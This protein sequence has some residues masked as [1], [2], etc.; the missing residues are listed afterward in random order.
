MKRIWLLTQANLRKSKGNA[1]SLLVM[2]MLAAAFMNIGFLTWRNYDNAFDMRAKE[3]NTSDITAVLQN[4]Y[5][6]Y[7]KTYE[8][9]FR[10][11]TR[12]KE[13]EV[14]DI[15]LLH[16]SCA[17]G[18][19]ITNRMVAVL[20]TKDP[21]TMNQYVFV[22]KAEVEPGHAVYLPYLFQ[23]AGGYD[24]GDS[25]SIEISSAS[26]NNKSF[27]Y[28][29]AG[30]FDEIILGTINASTT[31]IILNDSSYQE[32]SKAYD[33]LLDAK[34]FLMQIVDPSFNEVYAT[35]H[36][37]DLSDNHILFDIN[38]YDTLKMSRTITSS[39]GSLL[40][41]AFSVILALISM[42]V[43]R[44]RIANTIEEDMQNIGALKA[45]GYKGKEIVGAILLQFLCI[46][47]CG[48]VLGI[49]ISYG[50]LPSVI[51]LFA[52]QTGLLWSQGF[53]VISTVL[54]F[55]ILLLSVVFVVILSTRRASKVP[56]IHA[57]RNGIH[58]HNFKKNYFPFETSRGS[59]IAM[60]AKK[61]CVQELKQ[62]TL[63]GFIILGISFAAV[64]ATILFYNI[65]M[66][67]DNFLET[68]VGEI[69]N[70]QVDAFNE[71][72]ASIMKEEIEDMDGVNKTLYFY[73]SNMKSKDGAAVYMYTTDDFNE[74]SCQDMVY[75]GR[76]P[77][78]ENEVAIGGILSDIV[79][80]DVGDTIELVKDDQSYTYVIT[81]LIQGSNFMGHDAAITTDGYLQLD[82]DYKKTSIS[83]YLDDNDSGDVVIQ[84]INQKYGDKI[85][86]SRDVRKSVEASMMTYR[87]IVSLLAC[88]I[89]V[90]TAI[91]ISLTLY[92]VIKTSLLRKKRELGIQKAIGFTSKQL[93]LQNSLSFLP[94]ILG[95]SILGGTITYFT[96]NPIL[97]MLFSG[98]G[99]MKVNFEIQ[100]WMIVL[101]SGS[102]TLFGFIISILVSLRI[103]KISPYALINE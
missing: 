20:N 5:P 69:V 70:L 55:I 11:D 50:A 76:F 73:T 91:V 61:T 72:D 101:I 97:S 32:L 12:T 19:S 85:A 89:L 7:T 102:I 14:R 6:D 23:I 54:T 68:T 87:G 63:I 83:V 66:N 8:Q 46:T 51:L 60:N 56:P 57:L 67:F 86:M 81:G 25:F 2:I 1:I 80:K 24:I 38:I 53:D 84:D 94:I 99:M 22:E 58:S 77:K 26:G 49:V 3:L 15:L 42:V 96:A 13:I 35:D 103:H 29:I 4:Q 41:V 17:Y 59:I 52:K 10:D 27:T 82:P 88:I 90:I 31:G 48:S 62:N 95:S 34:M 100:L 16:G 36:M 9:Q 47:I 98:I 18:D 75:E 43:I 40:V 65:S 33:G 71:E 92:L 28:E 37:A 64:F 44:F 30:F 78:Y 39:I 74:F 21:T 93:I 79:H 45:I